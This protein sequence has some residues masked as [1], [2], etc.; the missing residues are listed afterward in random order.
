MTKFRVEVKVDS[1]W[2][3]IADVATLEQA[4]KEIAHQK[5]MDAVQEEDNEYRIVEL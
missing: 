2:G 1:E 5:K 3:T 4:E